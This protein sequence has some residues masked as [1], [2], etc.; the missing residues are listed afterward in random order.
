PLPVRHSKA[1]TGRVDEPLRLSLLPLPR[2]GTRIGC[3]VEACG[4]GKT[5][6]SAFS[7]AVAHRRV[8]GRW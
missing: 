1:S 4:K 8:S 6:Y 5:M 2:R 7:M 3:A